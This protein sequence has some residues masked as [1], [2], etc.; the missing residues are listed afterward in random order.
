M[1]FDLKTLLSTVKG[2]V[3]AELVDIFMCH[4]YV[5]MIKVVDYLMMSNF[6]WT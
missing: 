4:K 5:T 3:K 2:K 6:W 1:I